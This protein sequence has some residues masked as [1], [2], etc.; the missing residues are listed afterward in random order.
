MRSKKAGAPQVLAESCGER[1]EVG[2]CD[3]MIIALPC[4]PS[5]DSKA[6]LIGRRRTDVPL[7]LLPDPQNTVS[8]RLQVTRAPFVPGE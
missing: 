8:P 1:R 3:I 6:A 2:G 5:D 4:G 7:Y